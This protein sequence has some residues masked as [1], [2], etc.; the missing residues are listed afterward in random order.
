M[1]HTYRDPT[2]VLF[3]GQAHSAFGFAMAATSPFNC[4]GDS[5]VYMDLGFS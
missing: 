1:N 5:K 2:L 4:P 3:S